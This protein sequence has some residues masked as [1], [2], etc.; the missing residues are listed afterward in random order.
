[1]H[2][3]ITFPRMGMIRQKL[4][5]RP[6]RDVAEEVKKE[7]AAINIAAHI[8]PRERIGITAGSRGIRN[9]NIILKAVITHLKALGAEVFIFP[10]MGSHGGANA[11]GQKDLLAHYGITEESM[12][13]PILSSME[14]REIGRTPEGLSV[15]ADSY[16]CQADQI[17]VINRL[18]PHTKFKGPLES[19]LCKMMTIG[20]GKHKGAEYYH[21]YALKYGFP[22]VIEA[23]ATV[24]LAKLP[25]LCGIAI[26]EDGYDQTSIIRA[27]RPEELIE[28][29]KE[30]LTTAKDYLPKLPFPEI[31]VLIVDQ[32]GKD[33]SG[34]G[35]DYNIIGRNRDIMNRWHSAQKIKRIFVRDLTPETEGNGLGIG[36]ADY[37]TERLVKK[38]DL[39]VMYTNALT[40]S[41]PEGAM[42]PI[43]FPNDKRALQACLGTIGPVNPEEAKIIWIKD[44]LS[45]EEVMVS[46]SL[47]RM[48]ENR[49]DLEVKGVLMEIVF[50]DRDNLISP[51]FTH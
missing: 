33:I 20:L 9:I 32:I 39:S 45:L 11:Q 8:K 3:N 5:N 48:T 1:M 37:T 18:K 4:V 49:M 15:F 13:V 7:L 21:K 30:L 36:M 46:E 2:E 51:F 16:A 40:A 14:V 34:A 38:L 25:V 29:E 26:I 27:V 24:V 47:F 44:T 41:G 50:D 43:Y 31:D 12:G 23:V 22:E 35:M 6:V 17:I 10:A 42:I 28:R 19:G